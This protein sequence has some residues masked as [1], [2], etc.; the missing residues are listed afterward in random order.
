[1]VF[2]EK[3]YGVK[4]RKKIKKLFFNDYLDVYLQAR[5]RADLA[6]P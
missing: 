3:E 4:R 1:M 2:R 5:S 6:R